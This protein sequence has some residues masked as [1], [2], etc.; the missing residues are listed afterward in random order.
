[1]KNPFRS[2]AEAY[3]FVWLTLGSLLLIAIGSWINV[4][5]GVAVFIAEAIVATWA[6]F[7]RGEPDAPV[8]Q[9]PAAHAENERRFLVIANETVGGRLLR[10]RIEQMSEGVAAKVLVVCPALNSPLK[11]WVS[12]E[13]DARAA[14]QQRLD[15]SLEALREA[16]LDADG[17]IGDGDPLQAI[18]DALRTFAPDELIISTHPE[19][20]SHWLERG[21]VDRARERFDLPVTHVV[22][23]LEAEARI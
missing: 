22:V 1:M 3:R 21:V 23:D 19:G 17:Q 9:A 2:E 20:R 8:R 15:R 4:W 11:H 16:G 18:E 6:L 5:V 12:D 7:F 10:E 13:D 14:A